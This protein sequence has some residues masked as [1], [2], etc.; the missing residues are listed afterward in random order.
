MRK[1]KS[2][3]R[4]YL[5]VCTLCRPFDDQQ[6]MR[7]RLET[8]SYYLILEAIKT[9]RYEMMVSKVH[10][11][12]AQAISDAHERYEILT[13]LKKYGVEKACNLVQLRARAEALH[14]LGMGV[15][16]AAHLAYAE[17]VAD[18]FISCDDKLLKKC[19]KIVLHVQVV[20][21]IEFC[22]QEALR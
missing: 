17:T 10:F 3:K 21:P 14:E 9:R 7:I 18:V 12:E 13:L 4:V 1:T 2:Q 16:D 22:T 20:N 6:Q 11:E 8:D 15:A 19:R 5:D